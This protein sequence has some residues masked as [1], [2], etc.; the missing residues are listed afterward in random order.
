MKANRVERMEYANEMKIGS[1]R[2]CSLLCTADNVEGF[3][4][5]HRKETE[6]FKYQDSS[7]GNGMCGLVRRNVAFTPEEAARIE[8]EMNDTNP[9]TCGNCHAVDAAPADAASRLFASRRVRVLLPGALLLLRRRS[10]PDAADVRATLDAC[11][12]GAFE[13]VDAL[14]PTA[15]SSVCRPPLRPRP[16]VLLP[17]A[18]LLLLRGRCAGAVAA[19]D[20]RRAL[21]AC[22]GAFEAV[23]AA[24]ADGPPRLLR[25]RSRPVLLPGALLLLRRRCAGAVAADDARRALRLRRRLR[26]R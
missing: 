14:P 18:L 13:A 16:A 10:A 22:A 9:D 8:F 23:D 25:P 11:A 24:L 1:R 12:A 5:A 17:G 15:A 20:V 21:D 19:A 6:K 4:C 26:G 3:E 2:Y 7:G